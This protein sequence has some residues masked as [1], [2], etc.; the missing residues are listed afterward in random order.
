MTLPTKLD[1]CGV[2]YE[3]KFSP[4]MAGGETDIVD[5]VIT[6]GTKNK[7]EILNILFHEIGEAIGHERGVR[8][9][10]Y[11]EGND[12]VRFLLTH[13][14]YENIIADIVAVVA[15]FPK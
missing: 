12:G 14:E 4:K 10:R 5:K 13:H 1:I 15:Q 7:K 9:T 11:E 2:T 8:Y 3:V 6:I